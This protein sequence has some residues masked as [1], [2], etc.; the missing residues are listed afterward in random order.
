MA[1]NT[2]VEGQPV[3]G[4][5]AANTPTWEE[6][7]GSDTINADDVDVAKLTNKLP[8]PKVLMDVPSDERLAVL[9]DAGIA[10]M[11]TR[12][13][14]RA[15]CEAIPTPP[16]PPPQIIQPLDPSQGTATVR[17]VY[18]SA[19]CDVRCAWCVHGVCM[20]CAWCVHGVCVVCDVCAVCVVLS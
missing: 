14:I 15:A 11:E 5:P 18:A 9:G 20:V 10:D 12:R 17:V 13:A 1:D 6:L 4:A 19:V 7:L 16:S 8:D 3:V 2:V